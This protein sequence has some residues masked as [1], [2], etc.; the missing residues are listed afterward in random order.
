MANNDVIKSVSND[1][2][3]KRVTILSGATVMCDYGDEP[4]AFPI[5]RDSTLQRLAAQAQKGLDACP[6]AC[7]THGFAEQ[8][9]IEVA[10]QIIPAAL[11]TA[12][13][14]GTIPQLCRD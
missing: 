4:K 2:A 3:V 5:G 9:L 8:P 14:H 11:T 1:R 6:T 12:T 7:I 10:K 13:P